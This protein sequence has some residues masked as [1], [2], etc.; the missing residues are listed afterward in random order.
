MIAR[1]NWLNTAPTFWIAFLILALTRKYECLTHLQ[2][3]A[4]RMKDGVEIVEWTAVVD[5]MWLNKLLHVANLEIEC[6]NLGL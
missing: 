1:F 2:G 5:E 4:K 6:N 3:L